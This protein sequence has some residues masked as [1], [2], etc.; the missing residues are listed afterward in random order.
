[1]R[2][3]AFHLWL[4]IAIFEKFLCI[5]HVF[6]G[7]NLIAHLNGRSRDPDSPVKQIVYC[8]D[9]PSPE[10]EGSIALG[11]RPFYGI[12]EYFVSAE[13]IYC[14]PNKADSKTIL[15]AHQLENRIAFVDRGGNSLLEKVLIL[16]K[17]GAVGI[18]I[19]DDGQCDE[20]FSYCGP[21]AGSATDGGFAAHD[22]HNEGWRRSSADTIRRIMPVE[23]INLPG[24]GQQNISILFNKDGIREEL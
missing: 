22:G 23:Q 5:N 18:I 15:N 2:W 13:V 6:C 12:K 20:R 21:R 19:A 11:L 3:G 4:T 8:V 17:T 16:Q 14:I 1:M 10:E 24:M 9:C 7:G